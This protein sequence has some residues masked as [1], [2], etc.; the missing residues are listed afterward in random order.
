MGA[1]HR[2]AGAYRHRILVDNHI[3]RRI[4]L[5]D[6]LLDTLSQVMGLTQ[7]QVLIHIHM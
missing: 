3:R 1:C 5:P 7:R 4:G 2:H 6:P